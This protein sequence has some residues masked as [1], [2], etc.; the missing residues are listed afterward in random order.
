MGEAR[1]DPVGVLGPSLTSR[2]LPDQDQPATAGGKSPA[3]TPVTGCWNG[4]GRLVTDVPRCVVKDRCCLGL[5]RGGLRG[6]ANPAAPAC[7]P[8]GLPVVRSDRRV[9]G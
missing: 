3:Q 8:G 7:G 6:A 1:P 2:R 4:D 5:Y 9:L